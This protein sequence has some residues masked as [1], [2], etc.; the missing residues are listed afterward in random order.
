ML[1]PASVVDIQTRLGSDVALISMSGARRPTRRGRAAMEPPCGGRDATRAFLAG[2]T[3][4]PTPASAFGII[5]GGRILIASQCGRPRDVGFEATRSRLS[6]GEPVEVMSEVV[7]HTR[8]DN[9]GAA[10]Y[11]GNRDACDW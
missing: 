11:R 8:T 3:A 6:V 2:Q 5:Q 9:G 10:R 1:T 4:A 7:R